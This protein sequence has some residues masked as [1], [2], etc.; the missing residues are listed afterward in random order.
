MTRDSSERVGAASAGHEQP[1]IPSHH[2][3]CRTI[4]PSGASRMSSQE[5]PFN[6]GAAGPL[7]GSP[8]V[9]FRFELRVVQPQQSRGFARAGSLA[10]AR[11]RSKSIAN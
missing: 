11:S 7:T 1:A 9:D 3:T 10:P 4:H 5:I 8:F 2:T 6:Q